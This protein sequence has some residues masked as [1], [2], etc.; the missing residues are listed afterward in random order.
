MDTPLRG[1]VVNFHS[2]ASKQDRLQY[3]IHCLKLD[4]LIGTES[5]LNP[6]ITDNEAFSPDIT[7]KFEAFRNDRRGKFGMNEGGGVFIL[8][9]KRFRSWRCENLYD[10]FADKAEMLWCNIEMK[11]NEPPCYVGAFY[12]P[13]HTDSAYLDFLNEALIIID[14]SRLSPLVL[15]G[16]DFNLPDVDWAENVFLT[17]GRYSQCSNTMIDIATQ[18]GLVQTVDAPTR[19]QGTTQNTLDLLFT[20]RPANINKVEVMPSIEASDHYPVF[21]EASASPLVVVKPPR[22]VPQYKRVDWAE[23]KKDA[24]KISNDVLEAAAQGKDASSLWETFM[25]GLKSASKKHIPQK[26]V[27]DRHGLPWISTD[28]K[29]LMRKRDKARHK[30]QK[31]RNTNNMLHNED[32]FNRYKDLKCKSQSAMRRA[33]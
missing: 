6:Q 7:E 17:N 9:S 29:R 23:Y 30:W 31:S 4:Y 25:N 15:L 20:N 24:R 19:V 32:L 18:H 13:E 12:R 1:A 2:V 11:A 21:V 5:W 14:S 8:V 3:L 10:K 26:L 22:Y 28:V 16:G 27:K 33:Y